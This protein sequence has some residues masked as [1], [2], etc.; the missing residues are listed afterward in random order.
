PVAD[1]AKTTEVLIALSCDSRAEVDDLVARALAAGGA[2]PRQPQDHGFMY[3]HGFEDLDG[4]IW[5]LVY[6]VPG[7]APAA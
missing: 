6:M 1:A 3:A 5:E 7:E 4:H 2:A